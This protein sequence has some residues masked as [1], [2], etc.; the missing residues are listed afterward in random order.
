V[1]WTGLETAGTPLDTY[2]VRHAVLG[3]LSTYVAGIALPTAP[4][5]LRQNVPNPFNPS[6]VIPFTLARGESVN[7]AIYDLRGRVVRRLV[8]GG[9]LPAGSHEVA[10]DGRGDDGRSVAAGVYLYSLRTPSLDETR[11]LTLAK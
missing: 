11:R 7:L 2:R 8:D 5:A 3:E 9:T 6:T 1:A 10:W 4:V